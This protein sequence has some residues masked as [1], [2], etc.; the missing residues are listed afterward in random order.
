[1][2]WVM[3]DWPLSIWRAHPAGRW[4]SRWWFP[5]IGEPE[6]ERNSAFEFAAFLRF[7]EGPESSGSEL[8]IHDYIQRVLRETDAATTLVFS[9]ETRYLER[10]VQILIAQQVERLAISMIAWMTEKEAAHSARLSRALRTG[11]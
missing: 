2:T 7:L 3:P 4:R 8:A 5:R 9:I 6:S 1:M 11:V 10:E